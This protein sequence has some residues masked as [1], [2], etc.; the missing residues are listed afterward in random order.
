LVYSG[1]DTDGERNAMIRRTGCG[2][3][4]EELAGYTA[5]MPKRDR[6]V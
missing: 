2:K 6:P 1:R 5:V 4:K 3:L